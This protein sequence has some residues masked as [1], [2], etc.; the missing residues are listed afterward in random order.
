MDVDDQI[1]SHL[2]PKRVQQN[3]EEFGGFKLSP[4]QEQD[5]F[6]SQILHIIFI[7]T[8]IIFGTGTQFGLGVNW[9]MYYSWNAFLVGTF[10]LSTLVELFDHRKSDKRIMLQ[11]LGIHICKFIA[12]ILSA[13]L[14]ILIFIGS[15]HAVH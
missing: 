10:F 13:W 4:T 3:I 11:A 14:T 6:L 8:T 7:A 15:G 9:F 12:G 5:L 2:L 1:F